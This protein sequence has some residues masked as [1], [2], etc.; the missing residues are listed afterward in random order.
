ME[1]GE[2][3]TIETSKTAEPRSGKNRPTRNRKKNYQ[4]GPRRKVTQLTLYC[5]LI[6]FKALRLLDGNYQTLC[7]KIDEMRSPE[8]GILEKRKEC[9]I[10]I[11]GFKS[12]AYESVCKPLMYENFDKELCEFYDINGRSNWKRARGS[13]DG[14]VYRMVR[15]AETVMFMDR[16]PVSYMF[17][18]KEPLKD[19]SPTMPRNS[20]YTPK[21]LNLSIDSYTEDALLYKFQGSR[22]NGLL[23]TDGG[24]YV[25]YNFSDWTLQVE[26]GYEIRLHNY[27]DSMLVN[28]GMKELSS[29]LILYR[30]PR[31]FEDLLDPKYKKQRE[32]I[33]NLEQ[34]Y[35][36]VYALP[37]EEIGQKMA[38]MM[39]T[40]N[41][42][43]KLYSM[44]LPK[45]TKH[46]NMP[47]VVND[48]VIPYA[49]GEKIVFLFCVPDIKRFR[50]FIAAARSTDDKESFEVR[51]YD[52]QADI[53]RKLVGDYA[54]VNVTPFEK[55]YTAFMTK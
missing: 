45:N 22:V 35:S 13:N 1:H 34:P 31:V 40:V 21:E 55:V 6:P 38:T 46:P 27:I 15:N 12:Y 51:C 39:C 44:L 19:S 32:W 36:N 50:S 43:Q 33:E 9:D 16:L 53:V 18:D 30:N 49:S 5:G 3:T 52:Y 10:W 37:L 25:I 20:F 26:S 14:F 42:K 2:N 8:E 7:K 54:Y 48:G 29:P 47:Y 11:I 17:G 24:S 4:K 23:T 28:K 41:W